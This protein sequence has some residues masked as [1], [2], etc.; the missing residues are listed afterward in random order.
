[1]CISEEPP[2]DQVRESSRAEKTVWDISDRNSSK[3][4]EAKRSQAFIEPGDESCK[5]LPDVGEDTLKQSDEYQ[6]ATD[7]RVAERRCGLG[8]RVR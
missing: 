6:R 2:R 3:T 5:G 8:G 4:M 7:A 1:M